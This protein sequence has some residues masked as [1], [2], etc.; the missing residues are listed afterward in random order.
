MAAQLGGLDSFWG[1]ALEGQWRQ[2]DWE[3][4]VLKFATDFTREANWIENTDAGD[5]LGGSR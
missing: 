5:S 4:G 1:V 3:L 2:V